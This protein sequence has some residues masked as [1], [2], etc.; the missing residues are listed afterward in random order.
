MRLVVAWAEMVARSARLAPVC[1]WHLL[2]GEDGCYCNTV[3]GDT[4]NG[5]HHIVTLA[6]A[7][8][9]A[10]IQVTFSG[11]HFD[12]RLDYSGSSGM[13]THGH[14]SGLAV[15]YDDFFNGRLTVLTYPL[16]W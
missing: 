13:F 5:S 15:F 6:A 3:S 9:S 12:V 1:A 4:W 11:H 10:Y 2:D 14:L 8:A 7:N 16:V